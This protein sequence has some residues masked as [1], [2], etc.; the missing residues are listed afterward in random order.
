MQYVEFDFL[1]EAKGE[2][3][4]PRKLRFTVTTANMLDQ[5]AGVGISELMA[6][7]QNIYAMVLMVCYALQYG[8][9]AMTEKRA[10]QLVQRFID[11]GGDTTTLWAALIKAANR[12]GV[13]GK[14]QTEEEEQADG[15]AVVLPNAE[16][17]VAAGATDEA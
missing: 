8:D 16:A 10:E 14:P 1:E 13:Y 17:P 15:A 4:P 12:S 6:R 9:P 2:P 7:R 11:K 5:R 3:K